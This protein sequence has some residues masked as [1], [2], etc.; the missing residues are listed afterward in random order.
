M[1]AYYSTA[2]SLH[3]QHKIWRNNNKYQCAESVPA[4]RLSPGWFFVQ[5]HTG[6]LPGLSTV[7]RGSLGIS[8]SP[9][10]VTQ[11]KFRASKAPPFSRLIPRHKHTS[12][13]L[14]SLRLKDMTVTQMLILGNLNLIWFFFPSDP[15]WLMN[16]Q[17]LSVLPLRWSLGFFLP[18]P[19]PLSTFRPSANVSITSSLACLLILFPPKPSMSLQFAES[20]VLFFL[21][22]HRC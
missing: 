20:C 21:N 13:F 4:P 19:S 12:C 6:V 14:C 3:H 2:P 1:G 10:Q 11:A 9:Q 22:W 8:T 7:S 17:V 18:L 15:R 16:H 5:E